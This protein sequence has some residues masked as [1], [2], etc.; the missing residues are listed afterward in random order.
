M[1]WQYLF[2]SG[3]REK[4]SVRLS[5]DYSASAAGFKVKPQGHT[6]ERDAGRSEILGLLPT[7][8]SHLNTWPHVSCR[9]NKF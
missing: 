6:D 5:V 3:A 9:G 4:R 8:S 7:L 1:T 2:A